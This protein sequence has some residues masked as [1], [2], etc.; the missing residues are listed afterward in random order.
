MATN[1]PCTFQIKLTF[2]LNSSFHMVLT[3][4]MQVIKQVHIFVALLTLRFYNV[5]LLLIQAQFKKKYVFK[6][7]P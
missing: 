5:F 7:T 6:S 4:C 3:E 1:Q 2:E